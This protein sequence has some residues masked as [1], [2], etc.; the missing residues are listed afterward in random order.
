VIVI[1][2]RFSDPITEAEVVEQIGTIGGANPAD[3]STDL[4]I[5]ELVGQMVASWM[6]ER[7][8]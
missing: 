5:K 7:T 2:L 3:A 4:D 1:E 6:Q 8:S